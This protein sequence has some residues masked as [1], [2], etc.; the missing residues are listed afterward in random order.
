MT[1]T[2]PTVLFSAFIAAGT[3]AIAGCSTAVDGTPT[4]AGTSGEATT[5]AGLA[6]TTTS[7]TTTTTSTTTSTNSAP[8]TA[9]DVD[10]FSIRP[11]DCLSDEVGTGTTSS[12]GVI[13]CDQPHSGEIY[14]S[15][16]TAS[17]GAYPGD[18]VIQ[19]EADNRCE[20]EFTPF[21]GVPWAS[22]ALD[23]S[24]FTPTQE[25]WDNYADREIL[26]IVEDPSGPTVGSLRGANR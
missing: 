22:S 9:E 13:S 19:D 15:V 16:I 17:T 20:E 23:I 6:D 14:A 7:S 1:L 2:K 18:T 3:V 10:V 12:L 21:V 4:A 5:Q 25:S 24:Y 11:G 26:C 8:A